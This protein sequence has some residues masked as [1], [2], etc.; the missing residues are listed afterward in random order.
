V[1]PS[2]LPALTVLGAGEPGG[3]S[4]TS[5]S[6]TMGRASTVVDAA[7]HISPDC[8][9]CLWEC[10]S[11]AALD[12]CKCLGSCSH[13]APDRLKQMPDQML[14]VNAVVCCNV[15]SGSTMSCRRC[16]CLCTSLAYM[17]RAVLP[18][19]SWTRVFDLLWQHSQQDY[20]MWLFKSRWPNFGN[21][22]TSSSH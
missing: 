22:C 20:L 15:S 3:P 10:P 8:K 1:N 7:S 19:M 4:G 2:A 6:H 13:P 18:T 14:P 21:C 16:G 11:A 9:H 5:T 12:I 17:P